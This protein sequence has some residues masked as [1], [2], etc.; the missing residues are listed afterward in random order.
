MKPLEAIE[1]KLGTP[2]EALF[3]ENIH[4]IT[5]R[6]KQFSILQTTDFEFTETSVKVIKAFNCK[7]EK[8]KLADPIKALFKNKMFEENPC[9]HD[10]HDGHD[11]HEKT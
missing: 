9:E 3:K 7:V 1:G 8:G 11:G 4:Q 10:G 2:D 5:I 6:I